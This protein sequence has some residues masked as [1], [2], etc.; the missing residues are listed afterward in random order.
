MQAGKLDRQIVLLAFSTTTDTSGGIVDVYTAFA[1]VWADIRDLR[2][3]ETFEAQQD[4]SEII[5]R[6]RI[7]YRNDINAR[8]RVQWKGRQYEI[9]GVPSE[10]GRNEGLE[11][12]GK[13]RDEL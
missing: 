8:D 10:I 4:N 6:F 3:K 13:A 7:R 9:I 2:E 5:T 12:M 11:I 1:T